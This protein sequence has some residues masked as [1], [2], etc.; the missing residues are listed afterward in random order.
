MST[1]PFKITLQSL[2]PILVFLV[3]RG[4]PL[5]GDRDESESNYV[6]LLKLQTK[7]DSR[8]HDWLRSKTDKYTSPE[9]QNEMIQVWL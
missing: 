7:D 9:M 5:R 4:L 8:V 2:A 3:R 6:Q 1:V